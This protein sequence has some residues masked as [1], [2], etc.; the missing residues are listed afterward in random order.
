MNRA[1]LRFITANRANSYAIA[2]GDASAKSRNVGKR[3]RN[4]GYTASTCSSR[5][6]AESN[7]AI[8]V[9]SG[10]GRLTIA[11]SVK[12][13]CKRRNTGSTEDDRVPIAKLPS[14]RYT[15][16]RPVISGDG[17]IP[18]RAHTVGAISANIPE[19]GVNERSPPTTS[20]VA[21]FCPSSS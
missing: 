10:V 2:S 8:N 12:R 3:L 14:V 4:P 20:P 9:S 11:G 18:K 6:L 15:K 19:G 5:V 17:A 7:V 16:L 21:A 13:A 1:R